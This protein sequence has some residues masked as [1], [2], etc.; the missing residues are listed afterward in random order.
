MRTRS[1]RENEGIGHANELVIVGGAFRCRRWYTW[2]PMKTQN[3]HFRPRVEHPHAPGNK[4][5]DRG[6]Y[7]ADRQERAIGAKSAYGSSECGWHDFGERGCEGRYLK[8]L[9]SLNMVA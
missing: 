5:Q 2:V 4:K 8:R 1:V 7:S 3:A 6:E 9:R